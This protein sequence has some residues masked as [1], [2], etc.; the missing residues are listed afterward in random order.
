MSLWVEADQPILTECSQD[1][2]TGSDGRTLHEELVRG[3]ERLY[4]QIECLQRLRVIHQGVPPCPKVRQGPQT[5]GEPS[6]SVLTP[7]MR[8]VARPVVDRV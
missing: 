4:Q 5:A 2:P 6:V 3:P 8:L 7:N 1:L